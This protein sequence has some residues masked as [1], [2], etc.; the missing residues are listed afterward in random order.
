MGLPNATFWCADLTAL[1][2]EIAEALKSVDLV[3]SFMVLHD[4][5][6][7]GKVCGMVLEF[8]FKVL[9]EICEVLP[10]GG[11][12]LILE[13]KASPLLEENMKGATSTF[14]YTVSLL[15]CMTQSLA[16][17]HEGCE[18]RPLLELSQTV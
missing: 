4:L 14:Y 10:T 16:G 3:T 17:S 9:K 15:H 13:N 18:G 2:S 8:N 1:P 11:R 7:P 12:I 6:F 5:S